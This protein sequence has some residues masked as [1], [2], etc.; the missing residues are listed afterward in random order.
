MC[1]AAVVFVTTATP[2]VTIAAVVVV[3]AVS[4]GIRTRGRSSIGRRLSPP[5]SFVSSYPWDY[6]DSCD[7]DGGPIIDTFTLRIDV[8]C[9]R[10]THVHRLDAVN[11]VLYNVGR[12]LIDST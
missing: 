8:H 1:V 7:V 12:A 9:N 2:S 3:V 5:P 4:S 6:D 11:N 10:R